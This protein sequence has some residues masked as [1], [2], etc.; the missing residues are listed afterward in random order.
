[1]NESA[2]VYLPS[3]WEVDAVLATADLCARSGAENFEIG[4]L[5]DDP[6]NPRWWAGCLIRRNG[7]TWRIYVEEKVGPDEAADALSRRLLAGASCTGCGRI[8][9]MDSKRGGCYWHRDGPSWVRGCDGKRQATK[10]RRLDQEAAA[11][12]DAARQV[13]H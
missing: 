13:E 4:H 3:E 10:R 1:M 2:K 7:S 12:S 6:R 9:T 8:V 11:N 5:S